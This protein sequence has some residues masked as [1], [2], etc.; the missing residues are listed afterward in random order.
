M[1]MRKTWVLPIVLAAGVLIGFG[2][3]L[4]FLKPFRTKF[5]SWKAPGKIDQYLRSH[6]V[7]KLQIGAGTIDY[8]DWLNTDIEPSPQEVYLDATKHLPF[9]S[10]SIQYI[11]GEH[12]I[13][14]LTYE[15]GLAFLK[16]CRRVLA[17]GGKIR[18]ATPNLRKYI[19]LLQEPKSDE[20]LRYIQTK[21]R[22]HGWEATAHPDI[23]ILNLEFRSFGHQFIYDPQSLS[24]VLTQAGFQHVST[25][26]PG[27][28]DDP[29]L[30]DIESRHRDPVVRV[31][32]DYESMV[33][34]AM[35]P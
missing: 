7:R 18:V 5:E 12:V 13:E 3:A 2:I 29:A 25:F 9:P 14:H 1:K 10:G 35:V 8:P 24:D 23:E 16:E 11:Y 4:P 20:Q 27:E 15:D 33:L 17:P 22:Y 28:S 34:Q 30:R 26:N 21:L 32:N 19:L 6:P 31:M